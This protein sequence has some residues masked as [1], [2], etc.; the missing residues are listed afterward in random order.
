[1]SY[2][3]K[4][5]PEIPSAPQE[6]EGQTNRLKKIDEIEKF[7]RKEVAERDALSKRCKQHATTATISDTSVITA[8]TALGVASVVTLTTGI[9][10][11]VSIALATAGLVLGVSSALIHK[12][13]K[14]FD[15]KAEKHEKIKILAESEL[16]SISGIFSKA[17]EDASISHDKYQFMLKEVEH[18]RTLKKQIRTK[19]MRVVDTITAKQREVILAEGREQ[20]KQ[21]FLRQITNTS[22][23][24]PVSAT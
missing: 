11:P 24:P 6:H 15:S 12:T 20:G 2:S 1:M 9:G 8:I 13:Q 3:E 22:V 18:Y 7:L 14:V 10:A 17:I 4:I 5:Y 23:T 19:S 16:D 21:H